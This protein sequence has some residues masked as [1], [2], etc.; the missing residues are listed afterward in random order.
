MAISVFE[1]IFQL[2]FRVCYPRT[3]NNVTA[4]FVTRHQFNILLNFF[5]AVTNTKK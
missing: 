3:L 2:L 1:N 4:F 5:I